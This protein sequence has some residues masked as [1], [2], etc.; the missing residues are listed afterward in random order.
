MS[1]AV[2][3]DVRVT[4]NG[5]V[6]AKFYGEEAVVY[7]FPYKVLKSRQ[8]GFD[9]D[10]PFVIYILSGVDKSGADAVYVGKST[11]G[12]GN[13]P[14]SHED[15]GDWSQ[16]FVVTD[17][18]DS[19]LNDGVIQ[20]MENSV[21]NRINE[22][23]TLVNTTNITN[24]CT[25]NRMDKYGADKL[26]KSAYRLLYVLGLD[27]MTESAAAPAEPPAEPSTDRPV[28]LNDLQYSY[29]QRELMNFIHD[30]LLRLDP[31]LRIAPVVKWNY[32]R[33]SFANKNKALVY[34]IMQ[35]RKDSIRALIQGTSDQFNDPDVT[36]VSPGEVYGGCKSAFMVRTHD[37]AVKLIDLCSKAYSRSL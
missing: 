10:N 23:G 31:H 29:G 18:S 8:A 25:A 33:F 13:R 35:R 12:I 28:T 6:L 3:I 17:K 22:V 5:C 16:C 21:W 27:L 14:T 36:P 37:D 11:S 20:Y 4:D 24:A 32:V 9:V 1:D 19:F 30:S 7:R 26:L 15:K 34:C 2:P